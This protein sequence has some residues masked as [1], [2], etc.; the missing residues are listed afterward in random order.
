[1]D[2]LTVGS[3]RITLHRG[4]I[5]EETSDA[6]V[7]AAN[8]SLLGGGGV[9]GAIHRRGGPEILA[10]CKEIRRTQFPSGLPTGEAVVTT[11]GRLPASA[12]IHTV[13][14]VWQGG[15]SNER[16]LLADAYHNALGQARMHGFR[17][18][19]FPSIS[20]G[21]YGFPVGEAAAVALRTIRDVLEAHP[22]AFDEVRM[23]LFSEA[24]LETYRAAL[25]ELAA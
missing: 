7:N 23:V 3:A 13:G 24:D 1:M 18:V 12:V 21:A 20:T 5:T 9:D 25:E 10:A 14:P 8:A 19:S 17:T 16:T 22:D 11:A 15:A 4:D 2:E 6:V